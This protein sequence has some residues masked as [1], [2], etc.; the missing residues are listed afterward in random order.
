[1]GKGISSLSIRRRSKDN[2]EMQK[3]KEEGNDESK[4]NG[5]LCL[6]SMVKEKKSRFYIARRPGSTGL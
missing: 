1:M 5:C 3:M 6:A 4:S 2:V